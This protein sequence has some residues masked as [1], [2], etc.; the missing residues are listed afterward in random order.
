M[1]AADDYHSLSGD[2]AA[3]DDEAGSSLTVDDASVPRSADAYHAAVAARQLRHQS[4]TGGSVV[5]PKTIDHATMRRSLVGLVV[6][7]LS[8]YF[9]LLIWG[10]AIKEPENISEVRGLPTVSVR[11]V[12]VCDAEPHRD[13][14][15]LPPQRAQDMLAEH[16]S[17]TIF[18]VVMVC[19]YGEVRTTWS[20]AHLMNA[21]NPHMVTYLLR[22]TRCC[23][24][25]ATLGS[26]LIGLTA[27]IRFFGLFQVAMLMLIAVIPVQ[28]PEKDEAFSNHYIVA[29]LM[30]MASLVHAIMLSIRRESVFNIFKEAGKERAVFG[31]RSF[32]LSSERTPRLTI[33]LA[34]SRR[35][36][37]SHSLSQLLEH[38]GDGD[39]RGYVC[40]LDELRQVQQWRHCRVL[41]VSV[42][43]NRHGVSNARH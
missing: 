13:L 40:L 32:S 24:S 33:A 10:I 42:H 6:F 22:T 14:H 35:A 28:P 18:Y 1:P 36:L 34:L 38:D 23:G 19:L 2:D 7:S 37:G 21:E 26:V 31:R 39:V 12:R 30:T 20:V 25:G 15:A 16:L 3:H 5:P 11:R 29:I 41:F 8:A 9:A 4:S 27:A 43:H 17:L